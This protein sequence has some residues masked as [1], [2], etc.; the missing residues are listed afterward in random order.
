ME[1]LGVHNNWP[2]VDMLF[3][4]FYSGSDEDLSEEDRKVL[5]D[6]FSSKFYVQKEIEYSYIST[7]GYVNQ[8]A[9]ENWK[10]YLHKYR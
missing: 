2:V 5:S 8:T 10:D 4:E 1:E 9:M 7:V 6:L 3:R